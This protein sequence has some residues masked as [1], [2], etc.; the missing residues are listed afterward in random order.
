MSSSQNNIIT[1]GLSGKVYQLV[2]KQWFGRTIVA[3]R[4]RKFTT[5]TANQLTIRENFKKAAI[6]AKAAIT[7][8]ALKLAYKAKAKPGQTAYN[9]AFADFFGSPEIGEIESSG[10]N[11]QVGST[12]LAP[13]TDDFRVKSVLVRIEKTNGS[14]MEEGAASLL[15]DGLNWMY[16]STVANGTV[17]GTKVSFIATDL[18]GNSITKLKTL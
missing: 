18:P 5:V 12:L 6:Y 15:P 3:K 1:E 8:A 14:L 7:D 10:Y 17:T 9:I 16:V 4:P 13:V 11:G 2:F